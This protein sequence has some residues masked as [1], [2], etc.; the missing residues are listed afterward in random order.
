M[1]SMNVMMLNFFSQ[2]INWLI[3]HLVILMFR[4]LACGIELNFSLKHIRL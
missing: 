4:L 3:L 2:L 1:M